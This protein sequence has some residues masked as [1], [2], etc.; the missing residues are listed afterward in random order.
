MACLQMHPNFVYASPSLTLKHARTRTPAVVANR[1]SWIGWTITSRVSLSTLRPA[2]SASEGTD[3]NGIL[4]FRSSEGTCIMRFPSFVKHRN[5]AFAS[6]FLPQGVQDLLNSM[7]GDFLKV[8]ICTDEMLKGSLWNAMHTLQ[9]KLENV[10][11]SKE[12]PRICF[13]SGLTGEELMMFVRA[14]P[15]A[16]IEEAVFAAMVPNN[17]LKTVEELI[18]EIMGDHEQLTKGRDSR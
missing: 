8:L 3:A 2:S 11:A 7:Q 14:F 5:F 6:I 1:S 18:E 17:A 4:L 13:L 16:N 10:K 9:P 15:D 12:V